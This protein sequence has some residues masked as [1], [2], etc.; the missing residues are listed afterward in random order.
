MKLF[1][2]VRR[3]AW[4]EV[5][6]YGLFVTLLAAGYYY[7][8]TFVQ[9]GLIDLGTRLVG[10]P[11]TTVSAWMGALALVTFAAAV[12]FGILMDR[13]G[14][15]RELRTK[16]RALFAVLCVQFVLTMAAPHVRDPAAFGA[17]IVAASV[18]MGVGFPVTFSL[19]IDFVPVRDRGYV[20]AAATAVAYFAGNVYPLEWS[21]GAFSRVMAVA[22]VPG[23]VVLGALALRDLG[24]V[25]AVADN[26]REFGV[27]RFCRPDTVQ[28]RSFAF[29]G[30]LA[31]MFG[32]FFV[33]SLGFLRIVETPALV[34]SA[35]QSPDFSVHLLIGAVH[36]VGAVAA[37]VLYT[38]FDRNWLFA[39]VFGLFA[40]THLLYTF[41][42]R[43]ASAVPGL[44]GGAPPLVNPIFY[45][46][47]VSFYTTLNFALWPD[48]STPATIGTHSAV[49]VGFAGFLSTFLSTAVAL[50]FEHAEVT[51][52]SHLSLVN[53]LALLL[54][55]ALGLSLY[56]RAVYR[57]ARAGPVT[58]G[59][60]E[61]GAHDDAPGGEP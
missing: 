43:L 30:P 17:W 27:G 57:H 23:L 24:F 25:D 52:I 31:L 28:L 34:R 32:V 6:G 20:A 48:L 39:W 42:L 54:F 50:Y 59:R 9:L 4:P 13:R 51:L 35:W 60:A 36:V 7:N 16:L 40:L 38:N 1:E 19:T 33:D 58:T 46:L 44:A 56:G 2:Y 53:A 49:G 47:T 10:L 61:R 22:M 55:V 12:G 41:D 37:G 26:H 3:G 21:I 29:L 14:W 11:A 18:S 45:A 5:V 15:S 8:I